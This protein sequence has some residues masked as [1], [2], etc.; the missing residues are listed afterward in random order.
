MAGLCPPFPP[1]A[2]NS[3]ETRVH[4][5]RGALAKQQARFLDTVGAGWKR[6]YPVLSY[7]IGCAPVDDMHVI[8]D[9]GVRDGTSHL[10]AEGLDF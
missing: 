3:V 5:Q 6:L 4:S 7:H 9:P 10:E 8:R 1:V 2:R